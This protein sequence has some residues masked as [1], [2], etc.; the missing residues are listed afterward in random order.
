M[1]WTSKH[2]VRPAL[3]G[4]EGRQLLSTTTPWHA[5]HHVGVGATHAVPLTGTESGTYTVRV[6]QQ[7]PLRERFHFQGKGTIAGLGPVQVTG[8]VT[9]KEDLSQAGTAMGVLRLSLEGGKGTARAIVS[10]TIPAHNGSVGALPFQYTFAGG[11]G[12]FRNG[13]DSGTGILTRTSTMPVPDGAKG[14]FI[15]RVV[16]SH[17]DSPPADAT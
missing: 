13:F 9:L 5:H 4:L 16:S 2:S 10:E 11:T 15:V 3:E 8:D 1:R 17:S 7:S 12:L 6:E 14:G